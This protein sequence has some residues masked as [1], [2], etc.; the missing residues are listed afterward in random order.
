M[1]GAKCNPLGTGQ[2]CSSSRAA[3]AGLHRHTTDQMNKKR[4]AVSR[5]HHTKP[6]HKKKLHDYN[7]PA[8]KVRANGFMPS[9][10]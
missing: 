8:A 1:A 7:I 9:S 2:S 4:V 3:A 10:N 6:A 5:A